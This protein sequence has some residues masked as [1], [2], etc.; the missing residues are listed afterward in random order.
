MISATGTNTSQQKSEARR[1]PRPTD[2]D[3]RLNWITYAK[4]SGCKDK[5][6]DK[7]TRESSSE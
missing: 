1:G 2:N 6:T 7:Q 3:P 5:E 4:K